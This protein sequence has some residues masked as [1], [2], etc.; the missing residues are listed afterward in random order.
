MTLIPERLHRSISSQKVRLIL[1][2]S[3]YVLMLIPTQYPKYAGTAFFFLY[4]L[5]V[6]LSFL[7]LGASLIGVLTIAG[8]AAVK[9]N[10]M[11]DKQYSFSVIVITSVIV[12]VLMVAVANL[13]PRELPTGSNLLSFDSKTWISDDGKNLDDR[14][15]TSRQKMLKCTVETNV[16]N[17]TR[18]Q[19]ISALGHPS[20]TNYFKSS[21][22]D[23]IYYLGPERD[24]LFGIDSEWLLIWFDKDGKVSK[25]QIAVD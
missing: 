24:S 4:V 18:E 10:S 21:G 8:I 1:I 2:A 7:I 6:A 3:F 17:Q 16:L 15:M 25:Y 11:T 22:R 23:L 9:R 12:V 19:V 20:E 5:T 14:L 13:L